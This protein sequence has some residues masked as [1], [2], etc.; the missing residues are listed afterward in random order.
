MYECDVE[1]LDPFLKCVCGEAQTREALSPRFALNRTG[2]H[3]KD[4][5]ST[6]PHSLR[7]FYGLSGTSSITVSPG[8]L[9]CISGYITRIANQMHHTRAPFIKGLSPQTKIT[10][11]VCLLARL[12]I[13]PIGIEPEWIT[14]VTPRQAWLY[15]TNST[16]LQIVRQQCCLITHRLESNQSASH[17]LHHAHWH[18]SPF[19]ERGS[20]FFWN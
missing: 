2:V 15:L 5:P 3:H 12:S 16:N 20:R 6:A 10:H 7:S 4:C 14:R 13:T 9:G 8:I 17:G 19:G 11:R 1:C 18:Q